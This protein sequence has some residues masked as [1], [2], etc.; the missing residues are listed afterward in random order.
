MVCVGAVGQ[1]QDEFCDAVVQGLRKMAEDSGDER[2]LEGVRI[3]EEAYQPTVSKKFIRAQYKDDKGA[4]RYIPLGM[5]D[6]D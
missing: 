6:V 5:T 3:I 1:R 4:W 2:F